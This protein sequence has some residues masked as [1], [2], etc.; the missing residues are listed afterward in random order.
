MDESYTISQ[1]LSIVTDT[2]T[3]DWSALYYKAVYQIAKE[4]D[5]DPD[6]MLTYSGLTRKCP[7]ICGSFKIFLQSAAKGQSPA[8]TIEFLELASLYL[9]VNIQYIHDIAH[10][11]LAEYRE[12]NKSQK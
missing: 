2:L 4:K 12:A 8:V 10:K 11:T 1:A 7:N 3:V 9:G 5:L 6:V